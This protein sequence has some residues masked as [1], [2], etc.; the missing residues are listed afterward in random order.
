V[1]AD[2]AY[3]AAA[4]RRIERVTLGLGAAGAVCAAVGWGARAGAGVATGAI[5]AWLNYRWLKLGVGVLARL[6][7]V[8]QGAEKVQVPRSVY[9]KFIGRYLLLIL[10]AYVILTRFGVPVASLLAGFGALVCAVL[11]EVV[12]QLFRTSKIPHT[13]C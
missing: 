5:L 11:A 9:F 6:S 4:E 7:K 12:A 1:A 10:G 2:E 13:D 3:Y 8:Q